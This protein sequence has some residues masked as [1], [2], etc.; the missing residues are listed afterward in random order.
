MVPFH[1]HFSPITSLEP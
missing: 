1:M